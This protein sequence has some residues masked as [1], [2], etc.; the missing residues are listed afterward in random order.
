MARMTDEDLEV[1]LRRCG[2]ELRLRSE[3]HAHGPGAAA[4]EGTV[5]SAAAAAMETPPRPS[6]GEV[7]RDW[8]VPTQLAFAC[9]LL[10]CVVYSLRSGLPGSAP[11]LPPVAPRVQTAHVEPSEREFAA[12]EVDDAY[13][14]MFPGYE[15]LAMSAPDNLQLEDNDDDDED[16]ADS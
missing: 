6:L 4:R 1:L 12:A 13:T 3:E 14:N 11:P 16:L 7:L 9:V 8:L 2:E 5:R 15:S 10:L